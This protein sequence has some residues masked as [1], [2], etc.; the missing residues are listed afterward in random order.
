MQAVPHKV[1][2]ISG[3]HFFESLSEEK[4]DQHMPDMNCYITVIIQDA[5]VAV[6]ESFAICVFY[7][8]V[9]IRNCVR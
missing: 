3:C 8:T 7:C 9:Q 4:Q 2:Q 6:T 1:C 5:V